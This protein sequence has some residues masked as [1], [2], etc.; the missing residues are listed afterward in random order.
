MAICQKLLLGL[1]VDGH[2]GCYKFGTFTNNEIY[3][4]LYARV[5]T[6]SFHDPWENITVELLDH[7]VSVHILF[8]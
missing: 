1:Y 3:E 2:L 8:Y 5:Y 6:E 7:V 4:H